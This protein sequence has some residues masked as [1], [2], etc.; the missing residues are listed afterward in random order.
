MKE[1]KKNGHF[2]GTLWTFLDTVTLC[3]RYPE[4][5]SDAAPDKRT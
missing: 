5:R 3:P 1:K 4:T 2:T